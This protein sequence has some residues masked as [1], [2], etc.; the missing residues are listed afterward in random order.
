MKAEDLAMIIDEIDEDMIEDAWAESGMKIFISERNP[1]SFW[2]IAVTVAACFA[3]VLTGVFC[4]TKINHQEITPPNDSSLSASESTISAITIDHIPDENDLSS[5]REVE[6]N[7]EEQKEK[8]G[9]MLPNDYTDIPRDVIYGIMTDIDGLMVSHMKYTNSD[10]IP[11]IYVSSDGE[12]TVMLDFLDTKDAEIE[13][14]DG[15][16]ASEE[17]LVPE[18]GVYVVYDF[19]AESYP[20]NIHCTRIIIVERSGLSLPKEGEENRILFDDSHTTETFF[21]EKFNNTGYARINIEETNAS[22]EHP[23]YLVIYN[24]DALLEDENAWVTLGTNCVS[25]R[26][27]ITGPGEYTLE[28]DAGIKFGD[29][30]Y[31]G[32]Y[33]GVGKINC[34]DVV[35]SPADYDG[36]ILK[37]YWIP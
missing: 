29:G 33:R 30:G 3:A 31:D 6:S 9:Q 10:G 21:A 25:D 27:K 2:K 35:C 37:G 18:T 34:L 11:D 24:A 8:Y 23:V 1:L 32:G 4:F 13:F 26:L 28:Y 15:S 36:L 19:I 12:K 14:E 16:P 7:Y 5:I 20:G 17:D 22:E